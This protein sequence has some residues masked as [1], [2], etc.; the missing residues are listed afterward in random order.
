MLVFAKC[1]VGMGEEVATTDS[2]G[3]IL[4]IDLAIE[5]DCLSG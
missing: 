2:E 3:Q 5:V 1:E 4:N